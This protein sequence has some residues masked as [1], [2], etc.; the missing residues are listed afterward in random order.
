MISV[1]GML[2]RYL[3]VAAIVFGSWA[4]S[5]RA[6]SP[7]VLPLW[8]NGAPGFETRK[9]EPEAAKDYW[10]K[11]IHNPSLTVFLP[12][13]GK[14]NG[15]AVVICPGGGHRELVFNAE[16]VEPGQYLASLGVTAFV[17]KYRLS[18]EE[19]SVYTMEHPA[20]DIKRAMRIVRSRAAEWGLNPDRIGVMGW[21]AGGEVAA[22]V[23]YQPV[24]GDP[25]SADS[26]E[27][28]NAKPDFQIIIYPGGFGTPA[29]LLPDAP[30]AF[31]FCANDDE[32]PARTISL[33]IEKYRAVGISVEAHIIAEG[34]HGFN[35]GNRSKFAAIR[36][37]PQRM[38]DWLLDRGLLT[39]AE[40]KK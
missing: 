25:T 24:P 7:V 14:A 19:G 30:P 5:L 21:S 27:R 26:V 10:V 15:T 16:G 39:P 20:A 33:M 12:P 18:R 32:S 35:M 1:R 4:A 13:P 23:A 6:D 34:A 2:H 31:F 37:L 40:A 29:K 36:G 8:A 17:L 38:G 28:V 22:R 9:N 11:N 3:F